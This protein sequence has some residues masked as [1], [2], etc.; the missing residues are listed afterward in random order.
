MAWVQPGAQ[1]PPLYGSK[2]DVPAANFF[3]V[4][5]ASFVFDPSDAGYPTP[6]AWAGKLSI[7]FMLQDGAA[8]SGAAAYITQAA[9]APASA[10]TALTAG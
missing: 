2:A 8:F 1:V 3:Y 9:V 4:N 5:L 10:N 6:A 7:I